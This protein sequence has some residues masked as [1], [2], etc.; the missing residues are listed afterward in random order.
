MK[1]GGTN[2]L[3]VFVTLLKKLKDKTEYYEEITFIG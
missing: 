1:F 3:L 2:N